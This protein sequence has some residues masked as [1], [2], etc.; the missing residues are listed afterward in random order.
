MKKTL[1]NT[2]DE[3]NANELEK[4]V[5]QNAASDV[6][7]DILSSI[8]S[9]VYAQTGITQAKAKKPFIFRWQSYI[10]IAACLFLIVGGILGAPLLSERELP[11]DIDKI[12]WANNGSSK[13]ASPDNAHI[14]V[15][16]NGWTMK[17]SLYEVLNHAN[18]TDYIAVIV[19]KNSPTD[20]DAFEYKGTTYG[21]L[22]AEQ[23]DLDTL[24]EKYIEFSQMSQWLKYGEQLYTTGTPDGTK[25]TKE[26]Y[27]ETVA[28]F[29]ED[30]IAKYIVNGEL[31]FWLLNDDLRACESRIGEISN[32]LVELNEVY[33]KSYVEEVKEVFVHS[34][35]C[36]IDRN[37]S[38]F[39]FVQ[40]DELANLIVDGKENYVLSLARRSVFD[41]LDTY[42]PNIDNEG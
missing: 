19:N 29:G 6:S 20:R 36:A 15:K 4:L 22:R 31:D 17:S 28:Y 30:F 34:G 39:L 13:P 5:S 40:K 25:W 14:L 33:H 41:G 9:K 1:N 27:D 23:T 21:K 11:T 24:R 18:E 8:K 10:V 32:A 42:T 16:W 7:A 2:F 37:G 35:V 3:A 26:H 12:L 38:V